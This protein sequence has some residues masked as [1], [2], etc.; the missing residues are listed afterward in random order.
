MNPG[1]HQP[2]A[3]DDAALTNASSLDASLVA[4][5]SGLNAIESGTRALSL[6]QQSLSQ[7]SLGQGSS[8]EVIASGLPQI[9]LQPIDGQLQSG[10]QRNG[11]DSSASEFYQ[12]IPTTYVYSGDET[13]QIPSTPTFTPGFLPSYNYALTPTLDL[14]MFWTPWSFE[15]I[16]GND[17]TSP[18]TEYQP[19]FPANPIQPRL[20]P[21]QTGLP[22]FQLPFMTRSSTSTAPYGMRS[23]TNAGRKG[24]R[25][26]REIEEKDYDLPDDE[27]DK[28]AKR[29]QRNKEAAARCRK[30]RLDLME[31]LQIQVDDLREEN[32]QKQ[33]LIDQLTQQK[34][35]L[36]EMLRHNCQM[37]GTQMIKDDM[38]YNNGNDLMMKAQLKTEVEEYE[39][40]QQMYQ[41]RLQADMDLYKDDA[42]M[43]GPGSPSNYAISS[44]S[45][46]INND[47]VISQAAL[48]RSRHSPLPS[49]NEIESNVC[50]SQASHPFSRP[51]SLPLSTMSQYAQNDMNMPSITTPSSGLGGGY[52]LLD[53]QTFLT[54]LVPGAVPVPLQTP[55]HNG[56]LRQL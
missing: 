33:L 8:R 42:M 12:N 27:K 39:Q 41:Q 43:G 40:Q 35:K 17:L 44:S 7:R 32:R 6:D 34:N 15:M 13:G 52:S 21:L 29:R 55:P 5:T 54:P 45:M 3:H 37:E 47:P 1:F 19:S 11:E 18:L 10:V 38:M 14:N 9:Y 4:G 2:S 49:I 30:R 46:L 22:D 48:K 24:G 31:A 50:H 20:P 36:D 51:T 28:R 25:R 16:N 56:E 53:Q 23:Q 26:P